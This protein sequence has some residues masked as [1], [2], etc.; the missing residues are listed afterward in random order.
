MFYM[1]AIRFCCLYSRLLALLFLE[2]ERTIPFVMLSALFS[3]EIAS[4]LELLSN[5]F[6]KFSNMG[7]QVR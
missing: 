6:P 1:L 5:M 3:H 7:N 4:V 2:V